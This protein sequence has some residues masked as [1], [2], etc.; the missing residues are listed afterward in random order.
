MSPSRLITPSAASEPERGI[1]MPILIVDGPDTELEV[2]EEVV[3]VV[4]WVDA[5]GRVV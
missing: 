4:D 2:V 1:V 5:G 3:D